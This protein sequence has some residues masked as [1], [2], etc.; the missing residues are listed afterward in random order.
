MKRRLKLEWL[1]DG[2]IDYGELGDGRDGIEVFQEP[3]NHRRV[4]V[5]CS[6]VCHHVYL[7]M[8]RTDA[9]NLIYMLERF[10]VDDR[11]DGPKPE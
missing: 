3:E 5:R 1:D 7:S 6:D 11:P 10:V 9:R 4:T 8:T 2:R